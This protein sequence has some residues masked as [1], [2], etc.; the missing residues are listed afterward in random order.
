MTHSTK[1][2]AVYHHATLQR[3][4]EP[5]EV[6]PG[7]TGTSSDSTGF[8]G[9]SIFIRQ[10]LGRLQ[11]ERIWQGE[12]FD[13]SLPLCGWWLCSDGRS[14][15]S[16]FTGRHIYQSLGPFSSQTSSGSTTPAP[17]VISSHLDLATFGGVDCSGREIRTERVFLRCHFVMRS[18][19]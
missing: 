16:D 14:T 17:N 7:G 5:V 19:W 13:Y 6:W 9:W 2:L 4:R 3:R 18:C 11:G 1:T 12:R 10:A 8:C 15:C